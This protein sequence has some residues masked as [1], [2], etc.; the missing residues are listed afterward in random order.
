[1]RI[2]NKKITVGEIKITLHED[3]MIEIS[4]TTGI[5]FIQSRPRIGEIIH[6]NKI[7]GII[8]QKD[9]SVFP[10]TI[11]VQFNYPVPIEKVAKPKI[12]LLGMLTTVEKTSLK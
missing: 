12:E 8:T 1:M 5:T 7:E 2:K 4:P 11:T 10:H 9:I 3:E 6:I